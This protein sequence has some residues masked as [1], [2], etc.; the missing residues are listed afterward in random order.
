MTAKENLDQAQI[1]C[2]KEQD[3][4]AR[5]QYQIKEMEEKAAMESDKLKISA[6]KWATELEEIVKH[7]RTS[8][9]YER[10]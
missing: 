4:K 8:D 6:D 2:Q 3:K 7:L 9:F 1:E 10:K 5:L